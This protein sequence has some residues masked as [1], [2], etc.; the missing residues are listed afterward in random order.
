MAQPP[1]YERPAEGLEWGRCVDCGA[2]LWIAPTSTAAHCTP[3][4][5]K[6]LGFA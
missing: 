1:T 5:A 6:R 4:H 3:C 2:P